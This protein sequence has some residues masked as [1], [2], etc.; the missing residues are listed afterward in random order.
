VTALPTGL[1]TFLLT[2]V[3]DSTRVWEADAEAMARAMA[4]HDEIVA[5]AIAAHDGAQPAEQG[6][7]DSVV[8]AFARASDA[9]AAA[10]DAQRG[11][12]EIGLSI[13]IGLHTG[14]TRVR[15]DRYAGPTIIR[16]ARLRALARGGQMSC[17]RQPAICLPTT[18][19]RRSC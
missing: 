10:I 6:E 7:G 14:E 4:R 5:T 3:E 15:D 12:L 16:A 2:D 19:R 17:R 1:V 8:G 13:R 18:S 11:L 9:L